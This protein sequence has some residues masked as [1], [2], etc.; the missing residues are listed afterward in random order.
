MILRN[1]MKF[2]LIEILVALGIFSLGI[3][4]GT[5]LLGSAKKRCMEA[6]RQWDEQ[7]AITQAAEYFLLAGIDGSIPDRLFPYDNYSVD[8]RYDSS[9]L[10]A[11]V[12]AQKGG[13]QLKTMKIRLLDRGNNVIK[14]LSID[15]II[16]YGEK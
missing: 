2:T 7:Q 3:L 6:Q 12:P 8:V 1:S 16:P 4:T 15:R 9:S 14:E 10:P 5:A 11:N 13:W